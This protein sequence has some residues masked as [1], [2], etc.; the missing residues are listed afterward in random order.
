MSRWTIQ[1][2]KEASDYDLLLDAVNE[3]KN[4]CTNYYSPLYERL[5]KLANHLNDL[6]IYDKIKDLPK[7]KNVR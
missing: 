3:R 4:R 1:E 5:Q 7:S 6:I 2:L